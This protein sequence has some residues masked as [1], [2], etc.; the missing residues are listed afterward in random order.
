LAATSSLVFGVE[1]SYF[2]AP[3]SMTYFYNSLLIL[4][5]VQSASIGKTYN[6]SVLKPKISI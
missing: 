6:V 4:P 5:E 1:A 2:S 3:A